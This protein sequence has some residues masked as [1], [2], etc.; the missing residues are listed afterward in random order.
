MITLKDPVVEEIL[1]QGLSDFVALTT[2]R[3]L[4]IDEADSWWNG[5]G[6]PDAADIQARTLA[7]C[8]FILVNELMHA[9]RLS[10]S[11][12]DPNDFLEWVGDPAGV[13]ERINA[14]W[15]YL[16]SLDHFEPCWFASTPRGVA[17]G[18]QVEG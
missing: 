10:N 17:A 8:E 13:L 15:D 14:E 5:R 16:T 7:V 2:I 1:Y 9:G 6:R 12:D 3:A 11:T 4:V 18:R